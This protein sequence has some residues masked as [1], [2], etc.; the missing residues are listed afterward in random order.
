MI[1][2]ERLEKII[3]E[4][5]YKKSHIAKTL[6]VR[7]ET[8]SRKLKNSSDFKVNEIKSLCSLL[9]ISDR[10]RDCIFFS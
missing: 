3:A 1:D 7:S 8:L 5:G 4:S 10:D 9:D 2:A 6:G